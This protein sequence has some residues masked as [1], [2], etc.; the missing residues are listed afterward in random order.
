MSGYNKLADKERDRIYARGS[1]LFD[2]S[3]DILVAMRDKGVT[4]AE[5]ARRLGK[6]PPQITRLLD[7][8]ANMTLSTLSDIAFELGLTL[9]KTFKEYSAH[10]LK[11]SKDEVRNIDWCA[12]ANHGKNLLMREEILEAA[13]ND[14]WQ[15]VQTLHQLRKA[16]NA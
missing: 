1:F 4:R 15:N 10:R 12:F 8:A 16:V 5:L 13:N 7:G 6:K 14:N 9:E 2:V 11:I 3:E